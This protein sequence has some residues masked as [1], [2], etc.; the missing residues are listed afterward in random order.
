M[1]TLLAIQNSVAYMGD[2]WS[3]LSKALAGIGAF[4]GDI[5]VTLIF[6]IFKFVLNIVDL[7][8]ILVEKLVGLDYWGTAKVSSS[9][10]ADS[11]I[12]FKFIYNDT[13]QRAFRMMVVIFVVLI[14]VFTV[15]AIVKSE[16]DVATTGD[17]KKSSKTP[18]FRAA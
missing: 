13:V 8:Q 10:L 2:F 17:T 11:D 14:I 7:L 4:L 3:W 16:Y 18:I 9:T 15:I 1:S 5:L 6:T 12:L